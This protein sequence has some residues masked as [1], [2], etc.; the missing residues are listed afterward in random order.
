MGWRLYQARHPEKI[1]KHETE[2]CNECFGHGI[3]AVENTLSDGRKEVFSFSCRLCG[4]WRRHFSKDNLFSTRAELEARGL[5]VIWPKKSIY[6][7]SPKTRPVKEM[8][9]GIGG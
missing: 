3:L 1:R 7:D 5:S 6:D 9:A 2:S 4:N 8:V